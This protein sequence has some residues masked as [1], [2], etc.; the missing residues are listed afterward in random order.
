MAKSESAN[1]FEASLAQSGVD[2][3]IGG[4]LSTDGM[5]GRVRAK[6]GTMTNV[7]SLAGYIALDNGKKIAFAILCNNFRCS[8]NFIRN[9]QD[10]LVRAVFRTV[11]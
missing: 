8:K 4:R 9:V 3:T 2:G 1:A 5:M 6:T 10:N 11:N 7:S